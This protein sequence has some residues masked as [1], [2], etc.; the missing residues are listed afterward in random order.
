MQKKRFFL[1]E[2]ERALNAR[3]EAILHKAKQDIDT[4]QNHANQE[5]MAV[6][7]D[8]Q[9][10]A[11]VQMDQITG[12]VAE[13]AAEDAQRRLQSTTTT[14]ITTKSEA[15]GETHMPAASVVTTNKKTMET[16]NVHQSSTT[17]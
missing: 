6:L 7:K 14:V 3:Q 13:M 2:L 5:K 9:T 16:Y 10:R 11:S 4:V 8:A 15:S 17:K 1:A 12:K